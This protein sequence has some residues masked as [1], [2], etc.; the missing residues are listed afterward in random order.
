MVAATRLALSGLSADL[1]GAP[2]EAIL[3]DSLAREAAVLADGS[4]SA[5]EPSAYSEEEEAEIVERLRDL[6]Y[7]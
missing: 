5:L 2:I 4:V 6:G 3:D 7:E 1:D